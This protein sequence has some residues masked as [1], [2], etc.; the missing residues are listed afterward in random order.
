MFIQ[1]HNYYKK[2]NYI[3][4]KIDF[5]EI[6]KICILYFIFNYYVMQ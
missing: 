5:I 1:M 2:N 3:Y 4:H 6:I